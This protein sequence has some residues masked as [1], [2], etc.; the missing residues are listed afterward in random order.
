[1]QMHDSRLLHNPPMANL[2]FPDPLQGG[3]GQSPELTFT[4]GEIVT[5]PGVKDGWAAKRCQQTF[6][7]ST[8]RAVPAKDS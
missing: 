5:V 3:A 8:P 6:V 7:Q 1:M 2:Q 4:D